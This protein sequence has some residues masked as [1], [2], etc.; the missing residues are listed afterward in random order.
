MKLLTILLLLVMHPSSWAQ[1]TDFD[2]LGRALANYQACSEVSIS[3]KDDLM[4]KY[5]QGMFNDIS[6]SLLTNNDKDVKQ[7]YLAW[8]KSENVLLNLNLETLKIICLSRFDELS[9][10]MLNK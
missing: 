9:R 1:K 3:I 10:K 4:F 8:N 6:I 7:A 2:E 5:Y